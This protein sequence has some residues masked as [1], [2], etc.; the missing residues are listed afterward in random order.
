MRTILETLTLLLATAAAVDYESLSTEPK[1]KASA[2]HYLD[3]PVMRKDFTHW[4][5][6]GAA[7]ILKSRLVLTPEIKDRRGIIYSKVPNSLDRHWLLDLEVDLG[8]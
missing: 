6:M 7:V 1:Y 5:T 8:N 3:F 2:S 4:S